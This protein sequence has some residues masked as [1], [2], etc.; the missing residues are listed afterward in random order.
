MYLKIFFFVWKT[1]VYLTMILLVNYTE[2]K[3]FRY[4]RAMSLRAFSAVILVHRSKSPEPN[5]YLSNVITVFS[6]SLTRVP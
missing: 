4:L 6:Y 3:C 5:T 1:Q 2:I